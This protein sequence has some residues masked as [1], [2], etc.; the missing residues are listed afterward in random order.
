MN[1][2]SPVRLVEG[3]GDLD[4]VV[5]RLGER[6]PAPFQPLLERLALDVL[7]DQVVN[8][9]LHADVVERADVR[10]VQARDDARFTLEPL[11]A[12]RIVRQMFRQCLDRDRAV[13]ARIDSAIHLAHAACADERLQI[14]GAEGASHQP[15]R[16]G[17]RR[18]PADR[19]GQSAGHRRLFH[20][21]F[22]P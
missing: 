15:A 7:D 8:V 1:D 4:G 16:R 6:E 17:S 20:E 19:A 11:P 22:G 14:V 18:E 21:A 9:V 10:M 3:I 2:V 12:V 13:Q 5:E